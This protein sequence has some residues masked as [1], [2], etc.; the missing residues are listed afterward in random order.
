[1]AASSYTEIEARFLAATPRMHTGH[2]KRVR[3]HLESERKC[4]ARAIF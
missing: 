3:R 4:P 1:M 2:T